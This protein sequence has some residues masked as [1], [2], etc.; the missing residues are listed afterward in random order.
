[1][2]RPVI[3][4]LVKFGATVL[5]LYFIALFFPLLGQMNFFHALLLGLAIAAIGYAADLVIPRAL[6]NMVAAAADFGL[7][8]AVLFAGS[9]L[10]PG[11]VLTDSFIIISALLITA[12]EVFFH[13]A[14]INKRTAGADNR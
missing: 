1:M 8:I 12:V 9:F 4:F 13:L 5:S 3:A 6:N 11:L 14:F 2:K 10:I 7:V